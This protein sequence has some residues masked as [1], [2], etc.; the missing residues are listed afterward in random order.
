VYTFST[1]YWAGTKVPT[2]QNAPAS[3]ETFFGARRLAPLDRLGSA[4][5]VNNTASSYYPFGEDKSTNPAIDAWKFG[6]YW[7]DSTSGL[8][9]ADQQYYSSSIGRFLTADHYVSGN[10]PAQPQSWNRYAYVQGDPANYG[11]PSGKD[12]FFCGDGTDSI[13]DGGC[14][15]GNPCDPYAS[16]FDPLGPIIPSVACSVGVLAFVPPPAPPKCPKNIMNFF[17]IEIPYASQLANTWSTSVND[18]LALSAYESGWLNSHNQNLHNPYGLTNAGGNNINFTTGYQAATNYW[19]QNDGSYIKG[20]TDI[21]KFA[22]NLQ[23]HY[24]TVN[25]GWAAT[26]QMV[27][28]SVLYWRAICG[29]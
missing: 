29:Q 21:A 27:Y 8:D 7:R 3:T 1:S 16:S 15:L 10:G 22:A 17:S 28:A 23:P 12:E 9:Y 4:R 13:Y 19:S 5:S 20:V 14:Y 6:S 26:L 2:L 25:P 24:N 18:V 11:D